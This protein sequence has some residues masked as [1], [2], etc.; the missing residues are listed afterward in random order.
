MSQNFA[1]ALPLIAERIDASADGR[2]TFADFM[3]VSLYDPMEGYYTN[4]VD[5]GRG[6]D[7][8]TWAD[9]PA[10]GA[11]IADAIVEEWK[12]RDRP[13][14]FTVLEMGAGTGALA[15]TVLAHIT[16]TA[17][18]L[19][20]ALTYKIAEVSPY[21][22]RQQQRLLYQHDNVE[23]TVGSAAD[24]PFEDDSID[25]M[26][27]SNELID[28]FPV[29]RITRT[30]GGVCER[31]VTL[32]DDGKLTTVEGQLSPGIKELPE[33]QHVVLGFEKLVSP[34][35]QKWAQTMGRILTKGSK[36]L[37]IDYGN[38]DHRQLFQ[39]H[40]LR[41]YGEFAVQRRPA[42]LTP[43][44]KLSDQGP[45]HCA[46]KNPG[47]VDITYD[48]NFSALKKHGQANGLR[49][50]SLGLQSVFLLEHNLRRHAA[51]YGTNNLGQFWSK[52]FRVLQQRKVS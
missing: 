52:S 3:D 11:C 9:H 24:L 16:N 26:A 49:T 1:P 20:D 42:G 43:A 6:R 51:D 7:F 29:H 50:E 25:G 31:F 32:G 19:S 27:F 4:R 38:T 37:T 36:L 39:K 48:I 12:E 34:Q 15:R 22:A 18:H 10:F 28:A 17:P 8:D 33:S 13:K 30:L 47:L 41:T 40:P 5:I 14:R 2:I 23:W 45:V 35:A 46:L 44:V 21:L